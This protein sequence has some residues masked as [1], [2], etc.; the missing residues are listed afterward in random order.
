[1]SALPTVPEST[2]YPASV[3][4]DPD[5]ARHLALRE[6]SDRLAE[7]SRR[8]GILARFER[9]ELDPETVRGIANSTSHFR[10]VANL[11]IKGTKPGR[12]QTLALTALEEAKFWT[13]QSI[14]MNGVMSK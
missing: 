14:A 1:M 5:L 3:V 7:A 8:A 13:N 9:K 4:S 2:V 6:N 10:D 11:I 12:E